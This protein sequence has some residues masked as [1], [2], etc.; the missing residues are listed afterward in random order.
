M[1]QEVDHKGLFFSSKLQMWNEVN[2]TPSFLTFC[3]LYKLLSYIILYFP[4]GLDGKASPTMQETQVQSLGQ[5]DLLKKETVTHSSILAWK[6][7]RT[8]EPGRLY[9][10]GSQRVRHD[11]ATSL[12]FFSFSYFILVCFPWSLF[13]N[14]F[15]PLVTHY[16]II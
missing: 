6:I 14:P 11:Q 3:H 15:S 4:S 5:E 16:N 2:Q 13:P 7:P 9:S 12:S 10:I 8:E 1:I